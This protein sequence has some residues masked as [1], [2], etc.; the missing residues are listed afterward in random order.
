[1]FMP[2]DNCL[3][4]EAFLQNYWILRV[5]IANHQT[6]VIVAATAAILQVSVLSVG[7]CGDAGFC[8]TKVAVVSW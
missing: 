8:Q 2:P 4:I 6:I 3:A 5:T 7:V 1:M